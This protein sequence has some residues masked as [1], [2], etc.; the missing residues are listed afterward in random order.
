VGWL[1]C[2]VLD[3]KQLP[4]FYRPQFSLAAKCF[5]YCH[6]TESHSPP[7]TAAIVPRPPLLLC[8]EMKCFLGGGNHSLLL[9]RQ[10]RCGGGW[11]TF[12]AKLLIRA[13]LRLWFGFAS[14]ASLLVSMKTVS[15]GAYA[16]GRLWVPDPRAVYCR[17]RYWHECFRD[18]WKIMRM[19]KGQS[20]P[21]TGRFTDHYCAKGRLC[22]VE[23]RFDVL[24]DV[25]VVS[26]RSLPKY[27][28]C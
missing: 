22:K 26:G 17:G 25:V 16:K 5:V 21:V 9:L 6:C 13:V 7:L 11:H 14:S 20:K 8:D 24:T 4:G 27:T 3:T 10:F 12:C 2:S 23:L 19:K 18:T 28:F 15:C 1:I